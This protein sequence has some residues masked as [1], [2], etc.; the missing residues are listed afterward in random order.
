MRKSLLILGMIISSVFSGSLNAQT[1]KDDIVCEEN[2]QIFVPTARAKNFGDPTAFKA[3]SYV[4]TN[5]G[6]YSKSVYI[7]GPYFVETAI[8]GAKSDREKDSLVTVLLDIYD[9]R[10]AYYPEKIDYVKYRKAL[11]LIQYYPD[12][13]RTA[14]QLFIEA[15]EVGGPEQDAAFYDGYF[16]TA[17]RLFNN[18]VYDVN[19]VFNSYNIVL[20]GIEVNNNV[21]NKRITLLEAK[22]ADTTITD[23]E[24]KELEKAQ[25]ELER[26]ETVESNAE[27]ILAPISTC[28][29]LAILYNEETFG[30]H[31]EDAV[32]LRRASKMLG[33]E[34]R[35]DEGEVEDC[36]D[37][38]VFF[39]IAEAL[40]QLEPSVGAARAMGLL[41]YRRSN[42]SK[43]VDYFQEASNQEV[44]P[45]KSSA[46]QMR[47]ASAYLKT[48]NYGAAKNAALKAA[49]LRKNW[50]DPYVLIAQLYAAAEQSCG[51][52]VFEKK[53]VYWAA[54]NKLEYARS[55]DPDVSKKAGRL[56]AN[57][58][59]NLPDKSISFQLGHTDGEKYTIGCIVNETIT[60]KFY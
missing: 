2:L 29:K 27:K 41:A 14:H 15:L 46:D 5:C 17:V 21:L 35:N 8:K 16:K 47:I 7:Y 23:K 42:Y 44:D 18:K 43:A 49:S 4:F 31:K 52:N 9:Q 33:K 55:I 20:E 48:G 26:Y 60:V 11:D 25:R 51:N 37:N 3:W 19:D 40:Y 56:I 34:K 6:G 59:Q 28:E 53:A 1:S 30:A 50:G 57:Y 32:W 10:I 13:I 38:P 24:S 39:K 22:V 45:K 36:T 54:I 58:K 12:S